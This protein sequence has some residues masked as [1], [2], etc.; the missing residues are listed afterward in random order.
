MNIVITNLLIGILA[1]LLLCCVGGGLKN[2]LFAY[3]IGF[4]QGAIVIL[5]AFNLN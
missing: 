5:I 3:L 2:K 1:G 4:I